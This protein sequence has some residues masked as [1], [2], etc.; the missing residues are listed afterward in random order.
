MS[1]N[2]S[3]HV[4][5]L[6]MENWV[7]IDY[8]IVIRRKPIYYLLTFALPCFMITIINVIGIFAPFNDAGDREE[9]VTMGLTTLLTMTVVLTI[10]ADRMPKSSE[11]LPLL[12]NAS[13]MLFS[14][15]I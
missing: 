13:S 9:K 15:Y 14:S 10:I 8:S 7:T 5:D 4:Y 2:R 3:V 11:G 1:A 6:Y 12:G